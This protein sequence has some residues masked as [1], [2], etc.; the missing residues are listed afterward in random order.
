MDFGIKRTQNLLLRM[1]SAQQT[2]GQKL[3]QRKKESANRQMM[4]VR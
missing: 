3:R 2:S 1:A 4:A